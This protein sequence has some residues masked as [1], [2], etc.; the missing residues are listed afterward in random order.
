MV[1]KAADEVD[2][3]FCNRMVKENLIISW[4]FKGAS[5]KHPTSDSRYL[6][7]R[8]VMGCM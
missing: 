1:R 3:V 6:V 7:E 4:V 5:G 8:T 2:V